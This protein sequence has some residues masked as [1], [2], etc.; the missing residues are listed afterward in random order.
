MYYP[1]GYTTYVFCFIIKGTST[2]NNISHL[3]K[4]EIETIWREANTKLHPTT[5][6]GLTTGS[7][8]VKRYADGKQFFYINVFITCLE[9]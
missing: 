7:T 8:R 2:W 9:K 5:L 4:R 1:C 3:G 6:L